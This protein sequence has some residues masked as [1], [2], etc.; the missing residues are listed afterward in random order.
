M[1]FFSRYEAFPSESE[2]TVPED[3]L[4]RFEGEMLG[5][6]R[7]LS[8]LTGLE[9]KP[10]SDVEGL[11]DSPEGF[12]AFISVMNSA[13]LN[14]YVEF[15]PS[16]TEAE[17]M[18]TLFEEEGVDVSVTDSFKVKARIFLTRKEY[19]INFFRK[20][21]FFKKVY[22]PGY[23]RIYGEFLE[24][25]EEDIEAFVKDQKE[26]PD[27]ESDSRKALRPEELTEKYGDE[28][29]EK[30]MK[31]FEALHFGL[32]ENSEERFRQGVK[33][34]EERKEK[35]EESC[36]NAEKVVEERAFQ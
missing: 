18:T 8:L 13:G 26:S 16:D 32:M 17:S 2:G 14:C 36:F 1:W 15:D 20:M 7:L 12:E 6:D 21:N 25:N 10:A 3:F 9:A 31:A 35:L 4:D 5:S 28:L 29:S 33:E 22:R 30:E 34:V 23:H 27:P 24:F 19:S 11:F